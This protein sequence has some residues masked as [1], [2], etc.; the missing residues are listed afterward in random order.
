MGQT[1]RDMLKDNNILKVWLRVARELPSSLVNEHMD[2]INE[3]KM[4]VKDKKRLIIAISISFFCGIIG[5]CLAFY[6]GNWLMPVL[7]D[8]MAM[9]L[10]FVCVSIYNFIICLAIGRFYSKSVW[11]TGFLINIIVWAALFGNLKGSGGFV[12]LWYGWLA[13]IVIAFTGSFIGSIILRN[14][15][16]K[17]LNIKN[18][19]NI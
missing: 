10:M 18:D 16:S 7:G 12:D 3:G 5:F 14:K 4:R 15:I 1:F 13:L 6:I 8:E 19:E 17:V 11:F 2:S 9:L